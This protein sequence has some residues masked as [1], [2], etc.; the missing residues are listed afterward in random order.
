MAKDGSLFIPTM[1]EHTAGGDGEDSEFVSTDGFV[2][3]TFAQPP[4]GAHINISCD[5]CGARE[6]VGTRWRCANCPN[7][8]GFDLCDRCHGTAHRHDAT[9]L[10]L[11]IPRPLPDPHMLQILP[12]LLPKPLYGTSKG[13][14]AHFDHTIYL[15]NA[16]SLDIVDDQQQVRASENFIDWARLGLVPLQVKCVQK[17]NL[18][19]NL[20]NKDHWAMPV[21]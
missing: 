7:Q 5:E 3:R 14:L 19:G 8:P 18:H 6:F 21:K 16:V 9:H 15:I 2:T 17:L 4:H 13:G 11:E 12:Q 10:F 20:E 1:H